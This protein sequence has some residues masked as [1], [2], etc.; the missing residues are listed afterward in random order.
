MRN[1]WKVNGK[2]NRQTN[3]QL[4][5]L[6]WRA[7]IAATLMWTLPQM[8][9]AIGA[10]LLSSEVSQAMN[11]AVDE[12]VNA[13]A[14]SP[15]GRHLAA[16]DQRGH[17][18]YVWDTITGSLV[19]KIP[20]SAGIRRGLAFTIDGKFLLGALSAPHGE[21]AFSVWDS[22]T[23]QLALNV[24]GPDLSKTNVGSNSAEFILV[25]P[26][27][28]YVV[29]V[30]GGARHFG[31]YET[32][33]WRL[34]AVVPAHAYSIIS[35]AISP[36]GKLIALG[37]EN[38][39]VELFHL[40]E[41]ASVLEFRADPNKSG[42][43]QALAFSP[44]ARILAT[45]SDVGDRADSHQL[46]LW[47]A[48]TA[49]LVRIYSTGFNRNI[50]SISFSPDGR[51]LATAD[52]SPRIRVWDAQSNQEIRELRGSGIMA[53]TAFSPDGRRLAFGGEGGV[54]VTTVGFQP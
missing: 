4:R 9:L 28:H 54:T 33:T 3:L 47:N 24:P 22:Q 36:D 49:E 14:W 17:H 16:S 12:Y 51:Y 31:V 21:F 7:W 29:V 23:G 6:G 32:T 34:Q 42:S 41:G 19:F 26:D 37:P 40:P 30:F 8:G 11:L 35:A 52:K 18:V 43:I 53:V 13:I 46:R 20:N 25:S 10:S 2:L 48:A 5:L 45:G 15:D 44:D 27:G 1:Y 38:G 39:N 50:Y